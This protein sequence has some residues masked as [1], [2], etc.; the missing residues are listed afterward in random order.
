M[1][2]VKKEVEA[3]KVNDSQKYCS[4]AGVGG[5][6]AKELCDILGISHCRHFVLDFN[7]S[8]VF[9]ATATVTIREPEMKKISVV[10]QK[11]KLIVDPETV[12][13]KIIDE[14]T[15]EGDPNGFRDSEQH[16]NEEA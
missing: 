15:I 13:T 8:D 12:E 4:G 7:R 9:T 5:E 14:G 16:K 11:Y 10:I 6:M 1:E 2:N 3:E